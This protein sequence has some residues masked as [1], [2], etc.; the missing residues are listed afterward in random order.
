M[1][2]DHRRETGTFLHSLGRGRVADWPDCSSGLLPWRT[3]M[4]ISAEINEVSSNR[5]PGAGG[6]PFRT[7]MEVLRGCLDGRRICEST[8]RGRRIGDGFLRSCGRREGTPLAGRRYYG[9]CD[10]VAGEQFTVKVFV[11]IRTPRVTV[12]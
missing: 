8:L 11:L 4:A 6:I 2:G 1:K 5:S 3:F 7:V 9:A 10:Y 12:R